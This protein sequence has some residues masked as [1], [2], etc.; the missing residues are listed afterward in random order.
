MR[1]RRGWAAPSRR[2]PGPRPARRPACSGGSAPAR[3]V[4]AR[5][6]PR[7]VRRR[8]RVPRQPAPAGPDRAHRGRG[9]GDAGGRHRGLGLASRRPGAGPRNCASPRQGRPGRSRQASRPPRFPGRPFARPRRIAVPPVATDR[10]VRVLDAAGRDLLGSPLDPGGG[11]ATP[12]ACLRRHPGVAPASAPAVDVVVPVYRD[13]AATLACLASVLETLPPGAR[14]WVVDDASPEPDL[15]AAVRALAAD[16]R[17]RL[18]RHRGESRLPRRGQCRAARRGAA[19]RRA[20]QQR[21]AGAAGLAGAAAGG[22]LRGAGLR[23]RH[24]AVQRRD[25]R[26][27][28]RAWLARARPRGDARAGPSRPARERRPRGGGA[29]GRRLLPLSQAGLPGPGG[30]VPRGRS[31]P[32]ATARRTI[33]ACAPVRWAG[34]TWSPRACS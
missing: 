1:S 9:L 12:V 3:G 19:G 8:A 5:A 20:A 13:R 21:R 14:V 27:L 31:S 32:K 26:E 17:V 30:P 34:G 4:A 10:P 29:H 33:G 15:A 25:A 6:Q 16:G 28:S 11:A 2:R 24:A 18:I 23:Q 22:C 7:R